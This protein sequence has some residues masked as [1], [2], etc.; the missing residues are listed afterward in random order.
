M[1]PNTLSCDVRRVAEAREHVVVAAHQA[2]VVV[3]D[4]AERA[5]AVVL[6]LVEPVAVVERLA[7]TSERLGL[8]K[9]VLAALNQSVPAS[10]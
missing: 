5:E 9:W 6:Q 3:V 2:A 1:T 7:Q 4:V 10:E 8:D